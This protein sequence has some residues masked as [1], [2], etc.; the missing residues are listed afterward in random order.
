MDE[1]MC[2]DTRTIANWYSLNHDV[3]YLLTTPKTVWLSRDVSKVT[4]GIQQPQ[5]GR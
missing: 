3:E 1:E 4:D 5:S 2:M